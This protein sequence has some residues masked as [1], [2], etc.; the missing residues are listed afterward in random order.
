[1]P[2]GDGQAARSH[3]GSSRWRSASNGGWT[4]LPWIGCSGRVASGRGHAARRPMRSAIRS[5]L[6]RRTV[7]AGE[8]LGDDGT[9]HR[10]RYRAGVSV[11]GR[12]PWQRAYDIAGTL[13]DSRPLR[14]PRVNRRA[15][16]VAELR[17]APPGASGGFRL[18]VPVRLRPTFQSVRLRVEA[19]SGQW[20]RGAL[21]WTSVG[22]DRFCAVGAYASRL[23]VS[24][25]RN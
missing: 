17:F 5:L 25:P 24:V 22:E 11:R 6:V 1:L 18:R 7:R 10:S 12:C 4:Q 21:P 15:D 3:R 16:G 13:T 8:A 20:S 14:K 23:L 9:V 19:T 2:Q